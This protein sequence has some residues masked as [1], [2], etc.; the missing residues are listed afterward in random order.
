MRHVRR[1]LYSLLFCAAGTHVLSGQ[2]VFEVNLNDRSG[3]TFKVTVYPEPLSSSNN[4]FQFASTAPGTYEE[5][6]IGRFVADFRAFDASGNMVPTEHTSTNEWTFSRP[7]DVRKI[8]YTVADIWHAKVRDHP[9]L[10]MC[11][12]VLTDDFAMINGQAVFGYIA[13]MQ[14]APMKIRL[15]CPPDWKIG[16]ALTKDPEGCYEA[17]DFDRAVDS[18]FYLGALSTATTSVGGATIDVYTYSRRGLV[19]SDLLLASL[20]GILR[21][22]ADFTKKLPVD[23]YTFLFYFGEYG[24]GAWEHSY[25]SEYVLREDTLTP[26]RAAGIVSTVAHEFFHVNIPLNLHSE[27]V[28]HFNFVKPVM[29]RHLWLYE[30]TTEWAA[31]ILQLRDSLMTLRQYLDELQ[32][33]FTAS[34]NFDRTVSLTTLGVHSTE[35]QDQYVN[36]YQKGALVSTLLDIRLLQLSGGKSGLRELI[37]RLSK[38]YGKKRAFSEEKFFDHLVAMTYPEIRDF[39]DRY[40]EGTDK[41]PAQE[42]FGWLGITYNEN[43]EADSSKGSFRV[44]MRAVDTALTV[45]DVLEGSRS[46]LMKGDVIEEIDG[47]PATFANLRRLFA[48]IGAL[49]PGNI[50]RVRVRRGGEEVEVNSVLTPRLTRHEFVVEPHPSPAQ[51]ALRDAWMR[52]L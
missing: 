42:Y 48:R 19:T 25:S 44:G 11:S 46:G 14:S 51:Q 9:V 18:P 29:S 21:A 13:G 40:I 12:S 22:E 37:L 24:A 1:I 10:R 31:Y 30:G 20:N 43:G 6:D 3:D 33:K 8:T 5:M 45:T 15:A 52:N 26:A 16:T 39:I 38:E 35:M 7:S 28:E 49:K 50:V 4:V 32:R 27:L 41:L 36:I 47:T 23:R 34:D 17:D 2:Q